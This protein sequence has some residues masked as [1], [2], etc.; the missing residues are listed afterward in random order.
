MKNPGTISCWRLAGFGG[1]AQATAQPHTSSRYK[2]HTS[3]T[4]DGYPTHVTECP[5]FSYL[6]V[7]SA[8]NLR[9]GSYI[10]IDDEIFHIVASSGTDLTTLRGRSGSI[11]AGALR[12]LSIAG[13]NVQI[14]LLCIPV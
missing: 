8:A 3:N 5:N 2:I 4:W 7:A 10:L 6:K 1:G 9:N 13:R 11:A 12:G 14:F